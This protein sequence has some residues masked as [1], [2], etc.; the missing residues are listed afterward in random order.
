MPWFKNLFVKARS[1]QKEN[2][3]SG[4]SWH[5]PTIGSLVITA[6]LLFTFGLSFG[7]VDNK[8]KSLSAL[9]CDN[10]AKIVFEVYPVVNPRVSGIQQ[11]DW[12]KM[13]DDISFNISFGI[14]TGGRISGLT[15]GLAAAEKSIYEIDDQTPEFSNAVIS[16]LKNIDLQ[17]LFLVALERN[18]KPKTKYQTIYLTDSTRKETSLEQSDRLVKMNLLF[19][20]TGG[21]PSIKAWLIV[22][23]VAKNTNIRE[24]DQRSDSFW[25]LAEEVRSI[26]PETNVN[27]RITIKSAIV[28]S[29]QVSKKVKEF[30]EASNRF[31]SYI[32]CAQ[33]FKVKSPTNSVEDWERNNG[34]LIIQELEVIMNQFAIELAY[35]I[36]NNNTLLLQQ[37]DE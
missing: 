16:A 30:K 28:F 21:R 23:V 29:K 18:L 25:K 27:N 24:L 10:D 15:L 17:Q 6:F 1:N 5:L 35:I 37:Y 36:F 8:P 13:L 32:E 9:Y 19:N 11:F 14:L 7:Q 26:T 31:M 4:Y 34:S 3:I 33:T 22:S 2:E 20:F 12:D